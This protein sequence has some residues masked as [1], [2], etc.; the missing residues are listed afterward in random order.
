MSPVAQELVEIFP[1]K[2]TSTDDGKG[3]N[4]PENVDPWIMGTDFT[5]LIIKAIQELSAKVTALENA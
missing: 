3:D 2:V 4:L 5:W 1:E